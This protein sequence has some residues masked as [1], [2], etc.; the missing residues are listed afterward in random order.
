MQ[1]TPV[2]AFIEYM[3]FFYETDEEFSEDIT[4][5]IYFKQ[6]SPEHRKF[7][8]WFFSVCQPSEDELECFTGKIPEGFP[9]INIRVNIISILALALCRRKD[10][11]QAVKELYKQHEELMLKVAS[12]SPI[13][14]SLGVM[15]FLLPGESIIY[16]KM[17]LCLLEAC[18]DYE[19]D[20]DEELCRQ[21]DKDGRFFL[22]SPALSLSSTC[23][24]EIETETKKSIEKEALRIAK[25]YNSR[26][27][28][29][30]KRSGIFNISEKLMDVYEQT[31]RAISK[32]MIAPSFSRVALAEDMI[33]SFFIGVGD[34]DI[35][36]SDMETMKDALYLALTPLDLSTDFIGTYMSNKN[37]IKNKTN[38]AILND[39]LASYVEMVNNI[40]SHALPY[41]LDEFFHIENCAIEQFLL[42]GEKNITESE[43][44]DIFTILYNDGSHT[45]ETLDESGQDFVVGLCCYIVIVAK[46][47]R[48]FAE[49]YNEE[50]NLSTLSK[51]HNIS[52]QEELFEERLSELRTEIQ[53]QNEK[54]D[55]KEKAAAT[56][57]ESLKET[58]RKL[59]IE[60][61]RLKQQLSSNENN[62]KELTALRDYVYHQK[63]DEIAI[64]TQKNKAEMCTYLSDRRVTVI[65]GHPNWSNKLK[66]LFP[67][68]EYIPIGINTFPKEKV[69][70]CELVVIVSNFCK[71]SMYYRT[72]S[73]IENMDNVS[74]MY[75]NGGNIDICIR[76][77]YDYMKEVDC[78][79]K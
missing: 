29:E 57:E 67:S 65:G 11:C 32:N 45:F 18:S 74:L 51:L 48:R 39:T 66:E 33:L 26:L 72:I 61:K 70:N 50:L 43:L 56:T 55:E 14:K 59:E 13:V 23:R 7:T 47:Y 35:Y 4:R 49:S 44:K 58:I 42:P 60:N 34:M 41:T 19:D 2:T 53:I 20:N 46:A 36:I 79:E 3:S 17:A 5:Y 40:N 24:I 71:H 38:R 62:T 75:L 68:W 27:V 1:E 37:A 16:Y 6:K 54:L 76:N 64:V 10:S 63:E 73:A 69:A 28:R 31:D 30:L 22:I 25:K 15:K 78:S 21:I 9:A 77:I 52:S 12:L 8:D